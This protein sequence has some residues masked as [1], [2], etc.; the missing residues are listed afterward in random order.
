MLLS[1]RASIVNAKEHFMAS[2]YSRGQQCC[3]ESVEVPF[4]VTANR[5]MH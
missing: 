1:V 4:T 5:A 3:D 2:V